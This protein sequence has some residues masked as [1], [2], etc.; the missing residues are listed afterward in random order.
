MAN[1]RVNKNT[2]TNPNGNNEVHKDS[3]P[4]YSMLT[5]YENLGPHS[6][7]SSAVLTAKVKG[8]SKAD[9]C[10]ICIPECHNG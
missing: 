9:G 2:D 5:N 4:H 6:S 7:C 1:Y 10:K 8:Y 3:C